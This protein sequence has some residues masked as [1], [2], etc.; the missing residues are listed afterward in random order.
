MKDYR[1]WIIINKENETGLSQKEKINKVEKE[2]NMEQNNA[3]FKTHYRKDYK[4]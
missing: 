4:E 1:K 3:Y 2:K